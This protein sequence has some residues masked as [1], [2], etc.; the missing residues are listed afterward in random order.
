MHPPEVPFTLS[1]NFGKNLQRPVEK[2]NCNKE[3]K[4]EKVAVRLRSEKDLGQMTLDKVIKKIK[5]KI[6]KKSLD[7]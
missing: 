2:C 5:E 6:Q 7:L 1:R 4:A 3:E